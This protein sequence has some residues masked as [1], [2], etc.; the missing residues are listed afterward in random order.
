MREPGDKKE[1]KK[2]RAH[3]LELRGGHEAHTVT[4]V[5]REPEGHVNVLVQATCATPVQP[6]VTISRP[7]VTAEPC[8]PRERCIQ[9]NQTTA[10]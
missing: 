2:K 10:I 8:L 3:L 6:H 7:A 4:H 5:R 1:K 9:S